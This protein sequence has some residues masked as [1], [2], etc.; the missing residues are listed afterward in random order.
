MKASV[1]DQNSLIE[2]QR[3][4]LAIMQAQHKLK[5]LPER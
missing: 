3:I 2:L 1:S 4:D 5:S